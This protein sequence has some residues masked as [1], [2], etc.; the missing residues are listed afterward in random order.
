[1][2]WD[3]LLEIVIAIAAG[4]AVLWLVLIA[5][6]WATKGRFDLAALRQALRLLPDLL[7]LLKRLTTDPTLPRGVR[8]RLWLL[9]AYLLMPIDLVPDFIPIIGYADDAI[10]VAIALRSVIRHAGPQAIQRHWPGTTDGLTTILRHG[11]TNPY[12][13]RNDA[14]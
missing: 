4:L 13:D 14:L 12:S 9:I 2:G 10:I 11:T 8:I 6:L 3:T 5:A 7:R 1:M